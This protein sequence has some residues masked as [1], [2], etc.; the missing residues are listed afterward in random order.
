MTPEETRSAPSSSRKWILWV[1]LLLALFAGFQFLPIQEWLG[2]LEKWIESLGIWGPIAFVIIYVLATVLLLPGAAMTPLSGLLFGLGPGTLYV[3]I[4]SNIGANIAFLIGRYFAREAVARKI[5]GNDKFAAIDQA[6]GKEGWKIVGLTRLS[7]V[8]PFVLLNYAYGLTS[9]RWIHYAAASLFGM[10]PGTVMYVY[11]GS[12]GKLAADSDTA[13]T[14]K[15][16]LTLVGLVATI[17]VTVWITRTARK[18]LS[19][20]TQIEEQGH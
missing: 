17:L 13:G 6:V 15:V 11:I 8:F 4:A 14:G 19:A 7:P 1:V 12:L 20:R 16:I 3:I 10:I 5:E 18:A 2:L 9:V